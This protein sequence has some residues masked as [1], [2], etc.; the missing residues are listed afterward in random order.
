[1]ALAAAHFDTGQNAGERAALEWMENAGPPSI[2]ASGFSTRSYVEAYVPVNDKGGVAQRARQPRSFPTARPNEP[3]VYLRWDQDLPNELRGP[4]GEVCAKV[5]RIGHSTSLAQMWVLDDAGAVK[6]TWA[7]ANGVPDSHFRVAEPGTLAYLERQFNAAAILRYHDLT[8]AMAAAKGREKARLKTTLAEEFPDGAPESS[9]PKLTRWQGYRDLSATKIPESIAEGPFDPD[10]L[11]FRGFEEN[12]VLGLPA[13]LQLTSALRNA[14][15][16]SIRE[17]VPE[18]VSGHEPNGTPSR[19]PHMAFFPL[20]F[21]GR[22]YADGHVMGVAI[23]LPKRIDAAGETAEQSRRRALTALLFRDDGEEKHIHLW[24][25]DAWRWNGERERRELPPFNLRGSTWTGPARRW[26]TVTPVVLHHFPRRN[27]EGEAE[28]IVL[29]A[30][31][32]AGLPEPVELRVQGF[33]RFEG[34]PSARQM[35]PFTEGGEGLCRYQAHV[36]ARFAQS[37]RGPVLVGRGRFRGYGL[38]RPFEESA[39]DA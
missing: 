28:R 4:L 9:R 23:A 32:S 6:P 15:M 2:Q 36:E 37:V 27:R 19:R 10:I 5:T 7:P 35:P 21:V 34:A 29:E 14:V 11:I 30:F 39:A 26:A 13:T 24:R 17:N 33:S 38:M 3:F 16:K 8:D 22:A 18:W 12:R 31:A 1:M 20:P 25:A